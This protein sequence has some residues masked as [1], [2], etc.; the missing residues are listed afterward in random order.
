MHIC[1]I[2][3]QIYVI[4]WI[5]NGML[6][7]LIETEIHKKNLKQNAFVRD[8]MGLKLPSKPYDEC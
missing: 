7:F 1:F 5:K 6:I 8:G 2:K 4:R 3:K